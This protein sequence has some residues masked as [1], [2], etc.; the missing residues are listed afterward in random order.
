MKKLGS[1]RSWGQVLAFSL[2]KSG[3]GFGLLIKK[4]DLISC[5]AFTDH[6]WQ[7]YFDTQRAIAE[8]LDSSAPAAA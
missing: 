2:E 1:C 7:V 4:Q 5:D 8:V 3:S 6:Y